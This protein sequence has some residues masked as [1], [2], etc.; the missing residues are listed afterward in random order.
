M[1]YT[2][3]VIGSGNLDVASDSLMRK[4]KFK[5]HEYWMNFYKD[6]TPANIEA[7]HFDHMPSLLSYS[8]Q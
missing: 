6:G 7:F 8:P 3:K 2:V 5:N 1:T 4:T